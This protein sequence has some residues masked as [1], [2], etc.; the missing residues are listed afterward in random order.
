MRTRLFK[1][2]NSLAVRIP[3]ALHFEASDLEVE[4]ERVGDGLVVRPIGAPLT[5]VLERF[6]AFAPNFM[7]AGREPNDE[8]EREGW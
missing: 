3:K 2:G 5:H 7:S 1:S 8:Q 6:A 4:I